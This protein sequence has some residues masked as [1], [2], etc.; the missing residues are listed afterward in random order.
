MTPQIKTKLQNQIGNEFE[1]AHM[2]LSMSNWAGVEGLP[3]L[4]HWL[5]KQYEEEL[6]HG[7]K[8]NDYLV[9][10]DIDPVIPTHYPTSEKWDSALDIALKGL[11]A[12]RIM[13][14]TLED[15]YLEALTAR[16]IKSL[17]M[18]QWFIQEQVEE[19]KLFTDLVYALENCD[20][21]SLIL[22]DLELG[23]R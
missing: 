17:V 8:I 15:I 23:K 16:D 2:Y 4:Q 22:Y 14:A 13:S 12:E 10:R 11:N 20:N 1:A 7:L 19:E 3:G 21:G 6:S 18:L 5:R 9:D